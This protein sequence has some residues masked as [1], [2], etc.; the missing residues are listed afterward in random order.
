M[1]LRKLGSK[2]K[3]SRSAGQ[4]GGEENARD[5]SPPSGKVKSFRSAAV[6]AKSKSSGGMQPA[7]SVGAMMG[8]MADILNEDSLALQVE[9]GE[10]TNERPPMFDKIPSLEQPF[11]GAWMARHPRFRGK[12]TGALM[13]AQLDVQSLYETRFASLQRFV[14]FAVL[15]HAMAQAVQ[16]FWTVVSLGLL[17]YDMSRTQSIMRIATTASPVSGSDV[18]ERMAA[19]ELASTR[20]NA[21]K[22]MQRN[23]KFWRQYTRIK[24]GISNS[25]EN[26]ESASKSASPHS[27]RSAAAA[28]APAPAPSSAET[29]QLQRPPP[30]SSAMLDAFASLSENGGTPAV[31]DL[32]ADLTSPTLT[33]SLTPAAAPSAA[34]STKTHC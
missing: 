2:N 1:F 22:T 11:L 17:G 14:G 8:M 13:H 23:V 20:L 10:H 16:D 18:R 7:K 33:Q 6:L 31:A 12:N 29:G 9:E 4:I 28:A 21:V 3:L 34:P 19:L 5:G 15:F 25:R 30:R 24:K 27:F 32:A 26:S